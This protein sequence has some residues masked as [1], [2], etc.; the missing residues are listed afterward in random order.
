M[1]DINSNINITNKCVSPPP[2]LH[3][4]SNPPPNFSALV[5]DLTDYFPLP[6]LLTLGVGGGHSSGC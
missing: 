1:N 2:V 4:P 6:P 5:F 3:N